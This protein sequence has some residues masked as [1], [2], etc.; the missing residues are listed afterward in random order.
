MTIQVTVNPLH[1]IGGVVQSE[2][3][4]GDKV[5]RT[6][7]C[8]PRLKKSIDFGIVCDSTYIERGPNVV[9]FE[10]DSIEDMLRDRRS[11]A[12]QF[13]LSM[14]LVDGNFKTMSEET[15]RIIDP[16]TE[17]FYWN[18]GKSGKLSVKSKLI[19]VIGFQDKVAK[20]LESMDTEHYNAGLSAL[21]D[22]DLL[23]SYVDSYATYQARQGAD[24]VL[25][26]SPLVTKSILSLK[27][28]MKVNER[29]RWLASMGRIRSYPSMY[30]PMQ[31]SIFKDDKTG[32]TQKILAYI[33]EKAPFCRF[34]FLK[35]AFY[36]HIS[37]EKSWRKGYGNF[38]REV[39]LIKESLGDSF[40]V[41]LLDAGE[42]GYVLLANGVDVYSESSTGAHPFARSSKKKE[43]DED[44]ES[45]EVG[46]PRRGKYF[47][48]EYGLISFEKLLSIIGED[49]IL[50]CNCPACQKYH[51]K[52]NKDSDTDQ[53]N[54][55]RRAHLINMKMRDI[56]ILNRG[57]EEG[58][59]FD[60]IHKIDRGHDRNLIDLIPTDRMNGLYGPRRPENKEVKIAHPSR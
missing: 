46:P 39:D 45:V 48:P 35:L 26:P 14:K 2:I 54:I 42:E 53:W 56:D 19:S 8:A 22:Q 49:A 23:V 25:P 21:N 51:G 40:V 27:T 57:I 29:T 7:N 34:L 5:L 31:S 58:N 17:A 33:R 11:A 13:D 44:A 15:V 36:N 1:R 20:I 41:V 12:N 59:V 6:P 18:L 60:V 28:M 3:S 9:V 38:M 10:I 32:M 55:S 43:D 30:I 52:L 47:H 16:R 4:V 37:S 24:F 50:P